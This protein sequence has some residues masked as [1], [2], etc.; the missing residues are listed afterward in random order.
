MPDE[1]DEQ[2]VKRKWPLAR[3]LRECVDIPMHIRYAIYIGPRNNAKR[4]KSYW[5][6]TEREAWSDARRRLEQEP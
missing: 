1:T 3:C 6:E 2:V 5:F 4:R